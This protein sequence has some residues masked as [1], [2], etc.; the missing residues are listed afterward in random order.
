[1]LHESDPQATRT[2]ATLECGAC[3][4]VFKDTITREDPQVEVAC[5]ISEGAESRSTRIRLPKGEKVHVGDELSGDDHRLQ[6][7]S[8]EQP[9]GDR[10]KSATPDDL[11]TLWCKVYDEVEVP[12]SV[13][14]GR[15]T[16]SDEVTARPDEEF[17]VGDMLELENL[18]VELH[19]IKTDTG[20]I[21]DGSARAR[22]VVR[23]YGETG[24]RETEEDNW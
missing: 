11:A 22:S 7:T 15:K 23:L 8:I 17:F 18:D 9:N 14:Q 10:I 3:G 5:V 2:D 21:R 20:V 4:Q 6:V 13:N 12:V 19:S 1:V 24:Y 16:W